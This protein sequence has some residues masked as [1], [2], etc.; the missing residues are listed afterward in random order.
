MADL[1]TRF[2]SWLRGEIV[3]EHAFWPQDYP[4]GTV[5]EH[6]DGRYRVTRYVRRQNGRWY[7]VRGVQL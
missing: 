2:V 7:E 5:I 3:I 1:F 6:G 4:I